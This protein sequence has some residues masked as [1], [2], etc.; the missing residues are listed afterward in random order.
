MGS[1][2]IQMVEANPSLVGRV[3]PALHKF[4]TLANTMIHDGEGL[5]EWTNTRWED[6]VMVLQWSV[7]LSVISVQH[8]D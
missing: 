8:S 7:L 4:V 6:F 5:E 3:I 2:P 1:L